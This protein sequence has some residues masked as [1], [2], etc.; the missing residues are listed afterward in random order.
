MEFADQLFFI[1]VHRES[2]SDYTYRFPGGKAYGLT[3]GC[4]FDI[5]IG[6]SVGSEKVGTFKAKSITNFACDL[7]TENP[8]ASDPPLIAYGLCTHID[9]R[10]EISIPEELR[11]TVKEPLLGKHKNIPVTCKAENDK[12]A[13]SITSMSGRLDFEYHYGISKTRLYRSLGKGGEIPSSSENIRTVISGAADFDFHLTRRNNKNP[14]SE[15]AL[16]RCY[17]LKESTSGSWVPKEKS[18]NLIKP[19]NKLDPKEYVLD[20]N[21]YRNKPLGFEVE[22]KSNMALYVALLY[23]DLG[24]LSIGESTYYRFVQIFSVCTIALNDSLPCVT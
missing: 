6:P 19:V 15:Q 3:K 24:N 10:F 11:Y 18:P 13:F 8:V 12:A 17:E 1:N 2:S 14:L 16:L 21:K 20:L 9:R 23:F 4:S 22:N 7:V 5:Y